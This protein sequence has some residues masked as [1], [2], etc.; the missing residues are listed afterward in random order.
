LTEVDDDVD[1]VLSLAET[2]E[3]SGVV[4]MLKDVQ[5]ALSGAS[6]AGAFRVG[7]R[8]KLSTEQVIEGAARAVACVARA[9]AG[10]DDQAHELAAAVAKDGARAALRRLEQ[11]L[12]GRISRELEEEA[13]ILAA[14]IN[15]APKTP[16]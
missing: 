2:G 12:R 15:D 6:P 3:R 8:A 5:G 9:L 10:L 1:G 4:A 16:Q 14:C 11:E 13:R 7:E